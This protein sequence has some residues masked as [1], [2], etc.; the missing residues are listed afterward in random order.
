MYKIEPKKDSVI[1][2]LDDSEQT[3]RSLW[4]DIRA[5]GRRAIFTVST[6]EAVSWMNDPDIYIDTVVVDLFLGHT[7]GLEILTYTAREFPDIRRILI[8]GQVL[9]SQLQLAR[10]S[11]RAHA[12]IP[13]PWSRRTLAQALQLHPRVSNQ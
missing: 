12:V 6:S 13:K 11:G 3:C 1:L 9:D 7:D 5:L 8:S 10:V 4:R 2:V